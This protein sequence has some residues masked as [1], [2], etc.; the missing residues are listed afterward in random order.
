MTNKSTTKPKI[1][2]DMDGLLVNLFNEISEKIFQKPHKLLTKE[3]KD[4]LRALWVD[5]PRFTNTFGDIREFFLNLKPF[6]ENGEI[7]RM[8]VETSIS[9]G[10]DYR[11]CSRPASIAP[12]AS[13]EGKLE[14]IRRNLDPKPTEIVLTANKAIYATENGVQ[15]ILIDDY[16]PYVEGWRKAGGKAIQMQTDKFETIEEAREHLTKSLAEILQKP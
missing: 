3:D 7:T 12:G 10:G 16:L 6:G 14:W 4:V 1:Y 2:L 9:F 11:I 5:H 15:N 13:A 8:I